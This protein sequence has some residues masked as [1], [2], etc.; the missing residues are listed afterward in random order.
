[1]LCI[2]VFLPFPGGFCFL[3]GCF[4]GCDSRNPTVQLG[5]G[6]YLEHMDKEK[7]GGNKGTEENQNV[8]NLR[9]DKESKK[10]ANRKII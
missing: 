3:S 4:C 9:L 2:F 10:K 8:D 1:M 5:T 6:Q 7:G